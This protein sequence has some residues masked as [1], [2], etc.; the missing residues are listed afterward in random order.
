MHIECRM[1]DIYINGWY[2]PVCLE[3]QWNPAYNGHPSTVDTYA[4]RDN[5]I[6]L[7]IIVGIVVILYY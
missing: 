6:C 3:I 1:I 7:I 2:L 5:T 4:I